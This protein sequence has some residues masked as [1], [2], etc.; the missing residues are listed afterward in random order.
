MKTKYLSAALAALAATFCLPS[1][2]ADDISR[3]H[4]FGR[5]VPAPNLLNR[6]VVNQSGKNIG[7][8]Q[9]IV[10]D[11]ESGRVLFVVLKPQGQGNN[12]TVAV[13]PMLFTLGRQPQQ[14][15]TRNDD[16]DE[17]GLRARAREAL[18][19]QQNNRPPLVLKANDQALQGAPKY[20]DSERMQ[21][22]FVDQVYGHFN[23]SRW[24]QGAG[25]SK[26]G[27]FNH[28]RRAQH[29]HK[30]SVENS[31]S[32]KLGK[33]ETALFD[34]PAGR[35][36]YVVLDPA[37]NVSGKQVLYPIPPMAFTRGSDSMLVLGTDKDKLTKAPSINRDELTAEDIQKLS[38]PNFALQVYN[39]WGKKPWFQAE[40]IP[41]PT[42]A[43]T[44]ERRNND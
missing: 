10:F 35:I 14:A 36:S 12:D 39:Y 34:L 15:Q 38:Q 37:S 8:I 22:S 24:W 29:I 27:T 32:E 2:A 7:Q 33:I 18:R 9:D 3:E 6:A 1:R 11:L 21:A 19:G 16:N 31:S 23:Q 25:D 40:N 4:R 30:L 43:A 41:S 20:V 5:A 26:T 42:G 13:P 44:G 17:G 28:V